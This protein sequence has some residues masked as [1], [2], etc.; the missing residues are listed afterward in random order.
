MKHEITCGHQDNRIVC[1]STDEGKT[2]PIPLCR[3]N[4]ASG[5][6]ETDVKHL[7]A[8]TASPVCGPSIDGRPCDEMISPDNMPNSFHSLLKSMGLGIRPVCDDCRE[9]TSRSC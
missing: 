4:K 9:G 8:K 6:V 7:L 3:S 5:K 2:L 1:I